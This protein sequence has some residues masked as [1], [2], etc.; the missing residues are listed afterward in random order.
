MPLTAAVNIVFRTDGGA[1]VGAGHLMR[2][3]ALADE[4]RTM[5]AQPHFIGRAEI[6]HLLGRV[7]D[8]GLPLHPLAALPGH[9]PATEAEDA[10]QTTAV[11]AGLGF[12]PDWLV[13]D[14]YRLGRAWQ[15]AVRPLVRRIAVIDDLADRPHD[16]DLLLDQNLDETQGRRY[17]GLLPRD[18]RRLIGPRYALL[19]REFASLR[20]QRRPS[21]GECRRVL[22]FFTAGHDLGETL[23]AVQGLALHVARRPGAPSLSVDVV[24]GAANTDRD[25]IAALCHAHGW[26]LHDQTPRIADLIARADLA[27]GAGGAS[28]WERCALGI[29]ALVAI[30]ADNQALV[31]QA[32]HQAGAVRCLG[33]GHG[34]TADDYANAMAALDG[35]SLRAMAERAAALV[36]ARGAARVAHELLD[37]AA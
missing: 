28:N 7:A 22:V 12:T 2:C 37:A 30:L 1:T 13:V 29:P 9:R 17:D 27:I 26:R 25:A 16:A 34:L 33:W 23:K 14:H 18:C 4:L 20:A 32:L 5:D 19:R 11:L 21:I 31:A 3:L 24:A 35:A 36:D 10:A 15:S 6:G 8:A